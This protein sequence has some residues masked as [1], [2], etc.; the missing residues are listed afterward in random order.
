MIS[1]VATAFHN[2]ETN[3]PDPLITI[4]EPKSY[5]I[6]LSFLAQGYSCPRKALIN[7]DI[8]T[9][10]YDST[11]LTNVNDPIAFEKIMKQLSSK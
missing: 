1:K 2:P 3:F 11:I 10:T 7:S 8:K 4:W 6:L 5:Q 9:L